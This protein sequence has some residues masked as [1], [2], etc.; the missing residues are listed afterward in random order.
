M[1]CSCSSIHTRMCVG[2]GF[3]GD[4]APGWTFELLGMDPA[5]FHQTGA[6]FTHQGHA[7]PLP[8]MMWPSNYGKYTCATLF[9]LFFG[10][11]T[12][13][14]RDHNRGDACPG[15]FAGPLHRR[16]EAG[17]KPPA[18]VP[19]CVGLRYAQQP[20]PGMIGCADLNQIGARLASY[21]ELPTFQ[22]MLLAAGYPQEA[23][24]QRQVPADY[25]QDPPE[26]T[27]G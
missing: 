13:A 1:T 26:P 10:G 2:A 21:G 17:G 15:I 20:S 25:T 19:A 7:G 18:G 22:G 3:G 9:T 23:A 8:K 4:G 6:A 11:N 14:P 5:K 16:G 12:F 27:W 24:Y